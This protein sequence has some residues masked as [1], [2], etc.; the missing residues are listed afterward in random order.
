[1]TIENIFM[2]LCGGAVI[3]LASALL[4]FFHNRVAGISGI[5]AGILE[6]WNPESQWRLAF[7]IG[8]LLSGPVFG[9]F[10][11][12]P[13]IELQASPMVLALAGLLVGYG[14]RLGG[15]CTSGHGIC[16]IARF[17]LRSVFATFIFMSTASV[18]VY[19]VR[20][21]I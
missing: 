14:S 2:A 15:G 4:L 17:S 3:G 12:L 20:H 19:V 1:V 5:A 6:R 16:G 13:A 18:T 7:L 21:V 9:L 8:L 10:A 11:P